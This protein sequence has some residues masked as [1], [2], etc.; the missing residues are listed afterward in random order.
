MKLSAQE[1]FGLRCLLVIA[2]RG[3]G[4]SLTIPEISELEAM[5]HSHVA[6]TLAILRK[7][8]HVVSTRGQ[9]G[10]YM[11]GKSPEDMNIK[12]ILFVLGGEIYDVDF[13]DRHSALEEECVHETDCHLRPLWL[14]LQHAIDNVMGKY[15]LADLLEGRIPEP[16]MQ[17]SATPRRQ[18]EVKT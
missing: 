4:A 9:Q 13:C 17:L 16:P 1:E 18:S 15:S 8:G 11:L 2:T 14:Q 10:G 3:P 7:S 12:D 6:K 5:S